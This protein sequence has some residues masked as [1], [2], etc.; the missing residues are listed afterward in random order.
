MMQRA[1]DVKPMSNYLLLIR[2]D[3]GEEKI[4]NCFSL[5]NNSLYS[6]I[7]EKSFLDT[8]HIDEMGLCAG[9]MQLILIRM[10]YMNNQNC[11]GILRLLYKTELWL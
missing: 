11:W 2:F 3:N 9:M 10:S 7:S 8:V 1:A 4:Y 6:K 5:L